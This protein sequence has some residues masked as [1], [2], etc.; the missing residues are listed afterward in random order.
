MDLNFWRRSLIVEGCFKGL[1][2]LTTP[3][4]SYLSGISISKKVSIVNH[5]IVLLLIGACKVPPPFQR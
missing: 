2:S 3:F 4:N 5:K 1:S